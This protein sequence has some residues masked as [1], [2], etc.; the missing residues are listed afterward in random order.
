ML[1][2]KYVIQLYIE[3]P[4]LYKITS[5]EFVYTLK[6]GYIKDSITYKDTLDEQDKLN[7]QNVKNYSLEKY[8]YKIRLYILLHY[9]NNKIISYVNTDF[10]YDLMKYEELNI[11]NYH[12]KG[13]NTE[14]SFNSNHED[15]D[16]ITFELSEEDYENIELTFKSDNK[17]K[18]KIKEFIKKFNDQINENKQIL[19]I[20]MDNNY[21]LYAIDAVFDKSD[22]YNIKIFEINSGGA[23]YRDNIMYDTYSL[24]YNDMMGTR[25]PHYY[26]SNTLDMDS[27]A[28]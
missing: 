25:I 12:K 5:K 1:Q 13:A 20:G 7:I 9:I 3:S 16:S 6:S 8:R 18:K 19:N 27:L 23:V 14:Y 2:K 15:N 24:I 26:I 10:N 22:D 11:D 17:P 28:Q 4:I 21:G